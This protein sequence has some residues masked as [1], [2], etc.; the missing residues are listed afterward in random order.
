MF[1]LYAIPAGILAGFLAGGRLD[2]LSTLR[3]RWAP[4][5]IAG[6][7]V[8]LVLFALPQGAELAA[9]GPA[10]YVGSTAAVLVALLVNVRLAG[11]S[12][13]AAGAAS[14]LLAIVANG[15]AMP[16][17]AET[18]VTAG[19]DPH[20]GFSNSVVTTT[21]ALEP[22][23]DVFAIPAGVPLANVFSIGD[24]LIAV[25]IAVAIAV[26]MRRSGRP[27]AGT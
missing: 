12:I 15:G 6:L 14:N 1:I 11:L 8:Q 4:L 18:L 5:A 20:D 22:L 17:R 26:A 2:G 19:L 7:L 13:V 27:I 25:G 10:V 24:A 16:V 23:T 3:F 21:P 9:I